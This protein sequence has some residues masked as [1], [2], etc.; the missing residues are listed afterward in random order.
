[1]KDDQQQFKGQ[2]ME[3]LI[4]SNKT[5]QCGFLWMKESTNYKWSGASDTYCVEVHGFVHLR[6]QQC[7]GEK[8]HTF[9]LRQHGGG[10]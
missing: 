5:Q 10:K 3:R 6:E 2:E 8:A 9:L 7:G 1:M 4:P